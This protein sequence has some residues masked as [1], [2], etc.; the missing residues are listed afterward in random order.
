[1]NYE[2][3]TITVTYLTTVF[4]T[5]VFIHQQIITAVSSQ[6]IQILQSFAEQTHNFVSIYS[7][8]AIHDSSL[9]CRRNIIM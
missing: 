5:H 4:H 3:N 8:H 7:W 2:A 1:M 9:A 6:S